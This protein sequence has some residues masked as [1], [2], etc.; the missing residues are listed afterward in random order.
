MATGTA[1]EQGTVTIPIW[2]TYYALPIGAGLM[3]LVALYKLAVALTGAKSGLE[4]ER[5]P[6]AEKQ[7]D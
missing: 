6:D 2:P 3:T 7:Y 1:I 4:G 5:I